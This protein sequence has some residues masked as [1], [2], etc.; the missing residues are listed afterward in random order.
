MRFGRPRISSTTFWVYDFI[1]LYF[2]GMYRYPRSVYRIWGN[3]NYS[4]LQTEFQS[5]V[6][7]EVPGEQFFMRYFRSA[8][9]PSRKK[10]RAYQEPTF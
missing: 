10:R 9:I 3:F 1:Y 2:G 7:A 6:M 5:D 4:C 8:Y